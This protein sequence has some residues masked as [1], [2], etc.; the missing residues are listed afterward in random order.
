MPKI[1]DEIIV[2]G[3]RIKNRIVMPP[4]YTFSFK[5]DSGSFFGRQHIKHYTARA[6]GGAGLIILQS[7][8]VHGSVNSTKLWSADNTS[9]LKQIADGCHAYGAKVMMQLSCNDTDINLLSIDDIK[10]TQQ[11]MKQAAVVACS[12]GFDG[13]EYHCAHG[14]F[15]CKFFDADYNKRED[16]YGKNADGRVRILTEI[17]PEIRKETNDKFIISAR[18]GKFEP[19]ENDGI[20]AAK[21]LEKA[22]LDMLHISWGMKMPKGQ[23]P[24]G[25]ICSYMTYNAYEI[26][27]EV[28]IPIIAVNEIRTAEQAKFIIENGYAEFVAIGRGMLADAE[29]A[30]HIINNE[31]VNKCFGCYENIVNKCSWFTDHTKCPARN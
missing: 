30:N 24:D 1:T 17:I 29:F 19:A 5:G 20:E 13:V 15:L 9:V 14:F 16:A 23:A 28:S 10:Q 11:E 12:L 6:Q 3:N 8:R 7:A 27:K 18:M 2:R 26:K 22:G 21:A 25:F 31:P 4:M